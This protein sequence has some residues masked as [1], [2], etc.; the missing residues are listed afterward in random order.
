LG[1]IF[2]LTFIFLLQPITFALTDCPSHRSLILIQHFKN[3][4]LKTKISRIINSFSFIFIYKKRDERDRERKKKEERREIEEIKI[5]IRPSQLQTVIIFYRKFQ[6]RRSMRPRKP[7][8][9]IYR[10]NRLCHY[11]HFG[12]KKTSSSNSKTHLNFF[13]VL[14]FFFCFFLK[15]I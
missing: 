2:A 4:N 12:A 5:E 11:L 13:S 3:K 8:D 14:I 15:I 1:L 10:V 7:N 6:L 9:E